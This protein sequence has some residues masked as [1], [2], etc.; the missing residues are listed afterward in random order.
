MKGKIYVLVTVSFVI[1]AAFTGIAKGASASIREYSNDSESGDSESQN[2]CVTFAC[3]ELRPFPYIEEDGIHC[4]GGQALY[5]VFGGGSHHIRLE[6][7][8]DV[9]C[10]DG[11][12]WGHLTPVNGV[13]TIPKINAFARTWPYEGRKFLSGTFHV[14]LYVDGTLWDTDTESYDENTIEETVPSWYTN[15]AQYAECT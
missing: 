2:S 8:Y 14:E 3:V 12:H 10:E 1:A 7:Y 4:R 13:Y 5:G 9:V 6:Y 11:H 15:N